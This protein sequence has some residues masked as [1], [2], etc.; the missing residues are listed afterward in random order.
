MACLT[1][2]PGLA[3]RTHIVPRHRFYKFLQRALI[4]RL[5]SLAQCSGHGEGEGLRGIVINQN[6]D[7]MLMLL[8]RKQRNRLELEYNCAFI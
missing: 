1:W 4:A 3:I 8:I 6:A 2:I 7:A 5:L